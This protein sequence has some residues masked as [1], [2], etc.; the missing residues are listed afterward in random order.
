MLGERSF[1]FSRESVVVDGQ[2]EGA[3]C[4]EGGR[5]DGVSGTALGFDDPF[6]AREDFG[7]GCGPSCADVDCEA[8][9]VDHDVFGVAGLDAGAGY[10]GGVVAVLG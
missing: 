10:D 5:G 2:G 6:D 7:A 1:E 3:G 4:L 9:G 8:R